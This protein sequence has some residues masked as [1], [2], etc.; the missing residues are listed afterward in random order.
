MSDSTDILSAIACGDTAVYEFLADTSLNTLEQSGLDPKTYTLVRI[1]AL[2]AMDAAPVSY[3]I[4]VEA[5]MEVVEPDDI[6][7]VLIALAPV[8]GSARIAAASSNILDA[9]F[10]ETDDDDEVEND[11]S[12]RVA[13][14]I[15]D[16]VP[17]YDMAEDATE[18]LADDQRELEAV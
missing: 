1:A 10:D 5:A 14:Q 15:L 6:R 16:E 9:Y 11:S 18:T 2:V 17:E 3:A 13:F 8:V 7:S 4:T 12:E